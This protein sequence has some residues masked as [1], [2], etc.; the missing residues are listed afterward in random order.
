MA[1]LS[2]VTE[3]LATV[4]GTTRNNLIKRVLRESKLGEYGTATGGSTSYLEDTTKL[5]SSQYSDDDWVDGWLR[6]SKNFDASGSAPEASISPVTTYD[7]TTNGRVSIVPSFGTAVAASDE[8]ELWRFPHPQMVLDLI[9]DCLKNDIYLPCWTLLSELPDFD[10]EQDNTSDWA[11]SSATISKQTSS[12][13]M[14]GKRYLRVL[15]TAANGYARSVIM[16]VEPSKQYY[17]S[18]LVRCGDTSTTA[19]LLAYDETNSAAIDSKSIIRLGWV[20]LWF[21][22]TAPAT[23]YQISIRL[24]NEEDAVTTE[25]DD[26]ILFGY[27]QQ[28]ISLPWWVKDFEQVKKVFRYIPSEQAGNIVSAELRGEPDERWDIVDTSFGRGKLQLKA[29]VGA[30]TSP[31]FIFGVRNETAYDDDNADTKLVDEDYLLA[32]VLYKLYSSLAGEPKEGYLDAKWLQT[33]ATIWEKRWKEESYKQ[34][35]RINQVLTT[36][37]PLGLYSH[38]LDDVGW[39]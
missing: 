38:Y 23:C 8:Y 6:I 15:T 37:T 14:S 27:D 18:A 25:W 31:L 9:D 34:M 26:V 29:R 13:Q 20:R 22:F 24:S 32:C 11:S 17:V 7:P 1:V 35:Q 39:R 30:V 33:Q 16:N 5:K 19:K 21:I 12:P 36:S 4:K 2:P 10:M 28:T 3:T